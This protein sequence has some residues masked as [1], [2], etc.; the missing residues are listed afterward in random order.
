LLSSL[1]AGA[2][3]SQEPLRDDPRARQF[4]EVGAQAY[5][6][7][8]YLLAAEAFE[9]AFTLTNRPGLLFS[10]AQAHQRQF[11]ATGDESHLGLAIEHFRKYL[12]R[13]DRGGRRADAERALNSLLLVAERLN[14]KTQ[15]ASV[16]R[17]GLAR[18]LLSSSTPEARITVNGDP[19]ESL[20]TAIDL[21][22]ERYRVLAMAPGYESRSQEVALVAG[23]SV[24]LHFELRPLPATLSVDGPAGAELSIDGVLKGWL[25]MRSLVLPAGN[26]SVSVRKP[27]AK[28]KTVLA[29]LERGAE[30]RVRIALESTTQRDAAWVFLGGAL[31]AGAA[32]GTFAVLAVTRDRSA[33]TLEERRQSGQLSLTEGQALNDDVAARDRLQTLAMAGAV[34][35]GALL[36]AGAL[37]YWLD[38][39][40]AP[41][42]G[43]A[44]RSARPGS[45]F[46]LVPVVG[47]NWG[48]GARAAF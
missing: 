48:F 18:L 8:Q 4:F 17:T 46:A 40:E 22:E 13:V 7:G 6:K 29:R 16:Q 33:Q 11:R 9:Q 12:A 36:G 19:V 28:T 20:P 38:T 23:T 15:D 24:A 25:P 5:S 27:G 3:Q 26:H 45:R 41:E 30:A 44:V 34:T 35:T 2:A 14:P 31:A 37:L 42:H 39:P 43:D 1:R 32:T 10:L 21:P 47:S